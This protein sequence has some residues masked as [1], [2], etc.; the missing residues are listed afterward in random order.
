M[1]S[2]DPGTCS[3]EGLP[4][5]D[6]PGSSPRTP[7]KPIRA[8][9][10]RPTSTI[11][12]SISNASGSPGWP[13][14]R[15]PGAGRGR[16]DVRAAVPPRDHRRR[17][18]HRRADRR[19]GA[20]RPGHAAPGR[21]PGRASSAS[22]TSSIAATTPGRSIGSSRW[23]RPSP[24][25]DPGAAAPPLPIPSRVSLL[26]LYYQRLVQ[27]DQF[28]LAK[29]A[30]RTIQE[31][32]VAPPVKELAASRL[33]QLDLIGK[34]APALAGTDVDGQPVKLADYRGQVVLVVFWA[35]WCVPC[36]RAGRRPSTRWTSRITIRASASSG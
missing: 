28:E 31:Q 20:R 19:E 22:W 21:L 3:V 36:A 4:C 6:G 30:F 10:S 12:S 32:S 8:R 23:P 34:P 35:T 14:C 5:W 9:P 26:E 29:K 16:P 13:S 17:L 7:R 2:C 15:P 11:S 24:A 18:R 25:S 33:K 1:V 27:A